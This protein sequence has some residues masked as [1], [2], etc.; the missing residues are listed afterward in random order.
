MAE[1]L[2]RQPDV[3]W[4]AVEWEKDPPR[5]QWD[6]A[7]V[8]LGGHPLQS[9]LWGDA[10]RAADGIAQHRWLARRH[11]EPLWMIRVEERRVLGGKIA[12]APRGPTGRSTALSLAMPTPFT[13]RLKAEGFSLLISDPWVE[14]DDASSRH[15]GKEMRRGPQTIWLDLAVGK[16]ALFSNLHKQVRNGVRRA[17]KAGIRVETTL[18]RRRIDEFV[19]LCSSIS[20]RKGFQSRVTVEFVNK[21]LCQSRANK[22]AEALLFVALGHENLGAGLLIIRAGRSVHLIFA[23]TNRDMRQDRVGEACQWGVIE[24]AIARGCTRYDLEGIDPVNNASVYEFKKRLGGK[25]ISLCGHMHFPLTA[26]GRAMSWL[27]RRRT[28]SGY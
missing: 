25:E 20:V 8:E 22:H 3:Q 17:A 1:P 16:D 12:W 4:D 13:E 19:E 15:G 18:D 24:W 6:C 7:L 27:V 14:A 26:P 11:G 21:L 5:W 28:A 23:G 2:S 10:R 9:C